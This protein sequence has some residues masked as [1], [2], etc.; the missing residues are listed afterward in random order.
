MNYKGKPPVAA[1][2]EPRMS[3]YLHARGVKLGLPISGTFE[4]TARCNFNCKMCYVHLQNAAELLP[5]E[6]PA[7]KWLSLARE[8]VDAGMMFLLLTGGEP[9]LRSDFPYIYTELVKMG[10]MV[11]INTNAS[12]WNDELFELFRRYPPSRINATLYGASEEIY[13]SLCGSPSFAR[14]KQNLLRMREEGLPVR[15]NVSLTPLNVGDMKEIDALSREL[16]LQA[17]AASYMYPPIRV[18]GRIGENQARFTAVEA[19]TVYAEWGALRS[20]P[21]VLIDRAERIKRNESADVTDTCADVEQEGV[22]C[23]AGRCAFWMTWDGRMLPCGTMDIEPSYPFE[24]GFSKAWEEV[25]A[26]TAAIRLP[27]GCTGCPDRKNCGVCASVCRSETG[28]FDKVPTYMCGMTRALC[29]RTVE[30][31][32][33]LREQ[34]APGITLDQKE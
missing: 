2:V 9:T 7:E 20:E 31:G 11:S 28:A 6:I 14:V 34:N 30:I 13:A 23:R 25:R 27:A 10:L 15:L 29:R 21:A 19:G 12:L 4:L 16:G 8:C 18:N 26:R 33:A 1:P 22:S 3:T 32:D 17:K 5:R 24:V